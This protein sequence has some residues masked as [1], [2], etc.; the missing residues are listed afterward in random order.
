MCIRDRHI[1]VHT[2]LYCSSTTP[3][4]C[5]SVEFTPA[6][7][8]IEGPHLL[9]IWTLHNAARL[10]QKQLFRDKTYLIDNKN[11]IVD[12]KALHKIAWHSRAMRECDIMGLAVRPA[13]ALY[14]VIAGHTCLPSTRL[15][16]WQNCISTFSKM[17]SA[18]FRYSYAPDCP[19]AQPHNRGYTLVNE[20]I[21]TQHPP[22]F[23]TL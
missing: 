20:I 9:H 15:K 16:T 10:S 13:M 3:L 5:S 1:I 8:T 18:N 17:Y 4:D 21:F 6:Y 23:G 22:N 19:F 12:W 7:S 14:H 2:P 11:E